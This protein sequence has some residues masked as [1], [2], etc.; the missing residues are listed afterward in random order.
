MS[1]L[2]ELVETLRLYSSTGG[3]IGEEHLAIDL[4]C[5]SAKASHFIPLHQTI[6]GLVVRVHDHRSMASTSRVAC[7]DNVRPW[8]AGVL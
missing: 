3:L 4:N 6:D 5:Q 1:G 7:G 8:K 2:T